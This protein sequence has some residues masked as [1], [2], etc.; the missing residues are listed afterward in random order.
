MY[1]MRSSLGEGERWEMCKGAGSHDIWPGSLFDALTL[2][3]SRA[4]RGFPTSHLTVSDGEG[5]GEREKTKA[6][7]E[8][9][10]IPVQKQVSLTDSSPI[11]Q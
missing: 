11:N 6:R 7:E 5:Y 4:K 3:L 2:P 1:D 9:T 10:H 8:V